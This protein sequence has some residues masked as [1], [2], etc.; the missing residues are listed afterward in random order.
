[1]AEARTES[2]RIVDGYRLD[3][4]RRE[5]LVPGGVLRD[6]DHGVRVQ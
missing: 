1:M 6:R 4:P 3:K 2:L 5:A